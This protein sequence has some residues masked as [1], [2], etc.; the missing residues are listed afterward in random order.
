MDL[1][2]ESY[3]A[4]CLYVVLIYGGTISIKDMSVLIRRMDYNY[5]TLASQHRLCM[6]ILAPPPMSA[7]RSKY[8]ALP[9]AKRLKPATQ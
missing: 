7:K 3:T 6:R 9:F 8:F 2:D 5:G 4:N 1:Y